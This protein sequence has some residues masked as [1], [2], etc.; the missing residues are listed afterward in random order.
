MENE[1]NNL[2]SSADWIVPIGVTLL[3]GLGAFFL[4][5]KTAHYSSVH[6]AAEF[7]QN[8][9]NDLRQSI[10]ELQEIA[11]EVEEN[12]RQNP[13]LYAAVAKILL[14]TNPSEEAHEQLRLE[15]R[16]YITAGFKQELKFND[17][18]IESAEKVLK[19]EW[20]RLKDDLRGRR[21]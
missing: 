11:A 4:G 18:L 15:A 20:D 10:L 14:L 5:R 19:I 7:R 13:K 3:T 9:I 6:K 8:W 16:N 12:P 1:P 17:K 21:I 2:V